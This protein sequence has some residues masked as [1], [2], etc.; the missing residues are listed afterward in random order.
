MIQSA[1]ARG[2]KFHAWLNP[3]RITGYLMSWEEVSADSPA[4]KWLADSDSSNDRNVLK[5]DGS[6]YYNPSSEAVKQ[7]VVNSV[8]EILKNYE[9]DG[10][11]FDDYFYPSVDDSQESRWFDYPEYQKSG[12]TKTAAQW[13]RDQ[14]SD[15][16]A[17]VYKTVKAEKPSV[18]FGISPQGYFGNLRSDTQV[19]A[20]IDR[21]LTQDGFV[22]YMMPQLYWGFEAKTSD[23]SPASFAF[24]ANLKSWTDLV[25]KGHAKLYLGLAMYRAGTNVSDH[26]TVSEW[27]SHDDIIS[28][29]V[30]VGR[31]GGAVSGYC[32][33][34]YESFLETAAQKEKNNLL[35]LLKNSN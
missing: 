21:W 2:L 4:K 9:V 29:Q 12:S 26:N 23:G 25:K 10:I 11:H 32:F 15:L 28:R 22:D 17:C 33:Y 24:T 27:L 18:T 20:D 30:L 16:V 19:F 13:R 6:W 35:S 7:M 8:T 14:V 34:S 31:A 3:Y 1:H 5:Q